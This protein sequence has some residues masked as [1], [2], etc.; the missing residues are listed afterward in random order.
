METVSLG[1]LDNVRQLYDEHY[2]L[3]H[4][5]G[6]VSCLLCFTGQITKGSIGRHFNGARHM[7]NY[8]K[9][10]QLKTSLEDAL[11]LSNLVLSNESRIESLG[12]K[13]WR[14][15]IKSLVYDTCCKIGNPDIKECSDFYQIKKLISK[16]ERMEAISLL[17]L[18]IWKASICDG[19]VFRTVN[20]MKEYTLLDKDFEPS[21]YSNQARIRKSGCQVII[22]R[23]L[24]FLGPLMIE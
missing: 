10:K 19:V 21:V 17:E 8:I 5:N 7:K 13:K 12:C 20:E 23:V 18:A 11:V 9:S 16:H 15:N 6:S 14:D 24:E 4:D 3:E 22:P 2:V 1:D